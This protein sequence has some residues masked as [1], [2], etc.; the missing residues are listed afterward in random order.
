VIVKKYKSSQ[1]T[2]LHKFLIVE[3]YVSVANKVTV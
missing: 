2:R 3:F 1:Q